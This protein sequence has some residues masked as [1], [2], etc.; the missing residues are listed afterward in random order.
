MAHAD[1]ERRVRDAEQSTRESV[2]RLVGAQQQAIPAWQIAW[3]QSWISRQ[4]LETDACRRSVAVS[5]TVVDRAAASVADTYR[6]RRVLERLRA[7]ALK[8]HQAAVSRQER[9]EMDLLANLRY[10][11]QTASPGGT[12]SDDRPD[13][14]DGDNGED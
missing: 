11:A 7:R 9:N 8:R 12:H 13:R 3:H 5:A 4:R 6:Q 10:V 14:A 1:A 2:E